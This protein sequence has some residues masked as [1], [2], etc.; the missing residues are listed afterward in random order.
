VG[1]TSRP[2]GPG[3]LGDQHLLQRGARGAGTASDRARGWQPVGR[4][5]VPRRGVRPNC[6]N[7]DS[8]NQPH[9]TWDNV[10]PDR[11][12]RSRRPTPLATWRRQHAAPDRATRL[13]AGRKPTHRQDVRANC[14]NRDSPNQPSLP[15]C[16]ASARQTRQSPRPRRRTATNQPAVRQRQWS[17]RSTMGDLG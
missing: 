13:I 1:T 15:Q 2:T 11:A 10:T 16:L 4:T 12:G 3:E 8:P 5:S 7:R 14:S 17:R 6:T 9:A